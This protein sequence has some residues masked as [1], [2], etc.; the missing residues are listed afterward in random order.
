MSL[1]S[2]QRCVRLRRFPQGVPETSDFELG[3]APVERPKDGEFLSR[4]LY[5]SLDP[6]LRGVISGRHLYVEKMGPGDIMPGRTVAE[7]VESR[8]PDY[9]PGD[10]ALCANGW[11][12]YGL[13][14]GAV[15]LRKVDPEDAPISAAVGVL[16]MPGLTAWAGLLH[17]GEP[18]PGETVLVSAAC[19]PVGCMVGQLARIAGCRAVGIAGGPEKCGIVTDEFG[20]DACIDYKSGDLAANLKEACPDGVDVY[21]D[22]VG[23]EV[24]EVALAQLALG[25]R[26]VLCGMMSGYNNTGPPLPGPSLIPVVTAR[27]TVRGLVVYD[28]DDKREDFLKA[29][30]RWLKEGRIRFREDVAD[31]IENAPAAFCRLMRGQN[32]G[33]ALVRFA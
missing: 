25:A 3:E 26:V 31:G 18:M 12:E 15:E 13:S 24:L 28:H 7:V 29:S 4:T 6:Y 23:G 22:N 2:S 21:F 30:T 32:V 27:A 20:F 10:I 19:G 5:L 14:R 17:L 33:K 16:G 1:P 9:A 8:H 11:Q